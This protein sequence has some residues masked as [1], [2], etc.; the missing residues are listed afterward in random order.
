MGTH[1]CVTTQMYNYQPENND[2]GLMG[3]NYIDDN[4]DN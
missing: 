3:A 4:S 2:D 1:N